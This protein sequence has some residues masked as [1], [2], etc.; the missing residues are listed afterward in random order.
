MDFDGCVLKWYN[1][2]TTFQFVVIRVSREEHVW[3]EFLEAV[4][5]VAWPVFYVRSYRLIQLHEEFLSWGS[6]L[7]DDL[8]PLINIWGENV[9]ET[10]HAHIHTNSF[11]Y[12]HTQNL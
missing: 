3:E 12:M 6:E 10:S 5:S 9:K 8:V 7:L 1:K 2:D 11:T 4:S